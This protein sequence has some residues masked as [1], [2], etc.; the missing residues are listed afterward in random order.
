MQSFIMSHCKLIVIER[1][2]VKEGVNKSNPPIENLSLLVTEPETRD[3]I[4]GVL[5]VK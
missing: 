4:I 3:S 5:N 1:V 2:F